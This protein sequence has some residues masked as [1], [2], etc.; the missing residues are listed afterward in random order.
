MFD[1]E[2]PMGEV[3][4]KYEGREEAPV[5][6]APFVARGIGGRPELALTTRN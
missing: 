3:S 6:P 5:V 4:S 2:W 1:R